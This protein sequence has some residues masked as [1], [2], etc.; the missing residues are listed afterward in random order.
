MY[1][2]VGQTNYAFTSPIT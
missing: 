2:T 1:D